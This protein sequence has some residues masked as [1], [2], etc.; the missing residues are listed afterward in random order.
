MS[1]PKI[2]R[3][4]YTFTNLTDNYLPTDFTEVPNDS[5]IKDTRQL[6]DFKKQS[7][8]G[9]MKSKVISAL[10]K[11]LL[12][13][14]IDTANYW[15][16]QLL[17][18][19][20]IEPLWNKL[21]LIATRN[22]NVAN[23]LLPFFLLTK[24]R[25]IMSIIL[26]LKGHAIIEL[27]NN[28]E[29]RMLLADLI[30]VLTLSRKRKLETL[31][32]IKKEDFI[33]NIFKSKLEAKDTN[34]ID[35]ILQKDDPSEVRIA[36]NEFAHHLNKRNNYKTLYWLNWILE[37]ERINRKKYNKFEV[38]ART[39]EGVANKFNK[40]VI[41]LIWTVINT[42]RKQTFNFEEG[43]GNKENKQI[44]ALWVLFRLDYTTGKQSSRITYLV[45][46]I[47]YM[48]S[49]IDWKIPL[50]DREYIHFQAIANI[51]IMIRNL[52]S[53]EINNGV[54]QNSKFDLVVHNHYLTTEKHPQ[55]IEQKNAEQ[56]MKEKQIELNK[57][58]AAKKEKERIE[59]IAKK[60]KINV[61]SMNKLN[62]ISMI[63]DL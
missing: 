6:S 14:K 59:K 60:Q 16:I 51:N 29:V 48:T 7:F 8:G 42:I 44:D 15:G 26:H 23:P 53:Q 27:R 2:I 20:S 25:K 58:K 38:A 9:Y 41:W 61:E 1:N 18:S 4:K 22:I 24:T 31:P 3:D 47:K 52:R 63:E 40:C 62:F 39:I 19:G 46:T 5:K 45:W 12:T 43:V 54:Y 57:I 32:K 37:W 21:L 56:E 11:E 55:L 30:S 28:S 36:I 34:L 50:I 49:Q 33:V 35:R 17:L 10:E 13:E